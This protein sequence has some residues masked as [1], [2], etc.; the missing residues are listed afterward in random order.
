MKNNKN[1]KS[2]VSLLDLENQSI[3][4]ENIL[5]Q[6]VSI[7]LKR[8]VFLTFFKKLSNQIDQASFRSYYQQFEN[9]VPKLIDSIIDAYWDPKRL[10]QLRQIVN[11]FLEHAS[12][13]QMENILAE[14]KINLTASIA[15]SYLYVGEPAHSALQLGLVAFEKDNFT[16]DMSE[17]DKALKLSN[18]AKSMNNSI[19]EKIEPFI[20][21]WKYNLESYS[22]NSV[23]VLLVDNSSNSFITVE[24]EGKIV[25]LSS[26]VSER[27]K[28][29]DEDRILINNRIQNEES[30]LYY[31]ILDGLAAGKQI[32]RIPAIARNRHYTFQFSISEKDATIM[33][34]SLGSATGLLVYSSIMNLYYHA[35]TTGIRK[36]IAITGCIQQN[37][38]ITSV[39]ASGLKSKLNAAFCSPLSRIIVP[40]ENL[41]E[42]V[43]HASNLQTEYPNRLLEIEAA[44]WLKSVTA[45]RNI[46][47]HQKLN[48]YRKLT[49]GIKRNTNK[50]VFLLFSAAFIFIFLLSLFEPLHW[51][52]DRNPMNVRLQENHLVALNKKNDFLWHFEFED[53]LT[54]ENYISSIGFQ[55]K[56]VI[57]DMDE[58]GKNEILF[59]TSERHNFDLSGKLYFLKNDG[60][61]EWIYD[62]KKNKNLIYGNEEYI[63]HYRILGMRTENLFGGIHCQIILYVAHWPYFPSN[64]T[65]LDTD[66]NVVGEYWNSGR[67]HSIEFLY[68][69]G[70]CIKEI[71]TGGENNETHGAVLAIL[72]P[73]NMWGS[74]PQDSTKSYFT[75]SVPRG[76]EK[77]YIRFPNSPFFRGRISDTITRI[78]CY[79]DKFIVVIANEAMFKRKKNVYE[80][81]MFEYTFDFQLN[82]IKFQ[83]SDPFFDQYTDIFSTTPTQETVS[84]MKRIKYWDGDNWV[85]KAVMNRYWGDDK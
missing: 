65:I 24:P 32:P 33:G 54:I 21:N 61:L 19:F 69:N 27:P 78:R 13:T 49:A 2:Q 67:L 55:K 66:K 50:L 16:D 60:K 10:L 51:W 57:R 44:R 41:N 36:S 3:E 47:E 26:N 28:D 53:S 76:S 71:I 29:V 17:I 11:N 4:L 8:I 34:G 31:S 1:R 82:L 37:G 9:Y 5:Q 84:Y 79:E 45:N 64:I 20:K 23:Q 14:I 6:P 35:Q 46:I 7:Y 22:A 38:R 43:Q 48:S 70:D 62:V 39:D 81:G 83:Y 80:C 12:S 52:R 68:F 40:S 77:Y 30:S 85:E 42:A 15:L 58:D 72:D 59:G 63:N 75:N 73:R 74:S 18:I 25:T 56:Y